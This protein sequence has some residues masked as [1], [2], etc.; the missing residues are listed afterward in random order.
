MAMAQKA[1][2]RRSPETPPHSIEAEQAVLGGLMVSS[3]AWEEVA[4]RVV[5][6]DFYQQA[7][8]L[9]FSAIAALNERGKPCDTLTVNEYLES[10]EK[11][12]Q[13]GGLDYLMGLVAGT[14]S[15]ANIVAYAEI[16]R[17]HS[18][19]RQ[20]I[21]N[22]NEVA[23]MAFRPE[24][25]SAKEVLEKAEQSIFAIAEQ[26][27]KKGSGFIP[28][29]ESLKQAFQRIDELYQS[30]ADVT[31][32][33]TGWSDLDQ[34]TSGLQKSDLIIVAA[35]P[36]MGKTSFAINIAQH[37]A[38]Q[39]GAPV[40]V[41][42][43][44]MPAVQ[45]VTRM[46]SSLGMINQGRLRN[47]KLNDEDWPRLSSAMTMLRNAKIFIDETPG[48][49]PTDLRARARRLKRK[50][51]VGLIVV[52]YL[53]LM[54]IDGFKENR[55]NEISEISRSLKALAKELDVPVIALSQ[56]NR[57][58]EQRP[59]KRPVMADLRESGAIEQ[60]ADIIIFIYRDSVYNKDDPDNN[61]AEIIIGKQ[62]NGE[63]GTVK[64]AFR[65][66]FTRFDNFAPDFYDGDG[67]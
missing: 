12:E 9:I 5:A 56:L 2:P 32:I 23:G 26:G 8:Q 54:K 11:A 18:V 67:Q 50:D 27:A 61:T 28:I 35:R 7:H 62:R 30:D 51:G 3:E 33:S 21:D 45:L 55:T 43:M 15:A 49:S 38:L 63:T 37:A 48:L 40:A 42:S 36:A 4:D 24:G 41:F 66:E 25:R 13:A 31:G 60:D 29:E 20:L 58:L 1:Q 6:G 22:A 59:N 65:G 64:L 19:L 46:L 57:S 16:V 44:E 52:D 17:E 34:M 53:Q 10:S 47:G 14:P 39:G